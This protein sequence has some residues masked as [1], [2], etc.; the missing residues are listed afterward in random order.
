MCCFL[1]SLPPQLSRLSNGNLFVLGSLM[2]W[3]LITCIGVI[4]LIFL[5]SVAFTNLSVSWQNC[6]LSSLLIVHVLERVF[7]KRFVFS[8]SVFAVLSMLFSLYFSGGV[9]QLFSLIAV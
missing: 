2:F 8:S 4:L 1:V 5:S 6:W 3:R 7:V 9:A